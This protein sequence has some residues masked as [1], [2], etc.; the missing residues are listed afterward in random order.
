MQW[1]MIIPYTR[2]LTWFF[3]LY[4][5]YSALD[6]GFDA[7]VA[8]QTFFIVS[9]LVPVSRCWLMC[10]GNCPI[11]TATSYGMAWQKRGPLFF[12]YISWFFPVFLGCSP[13]VCKVKS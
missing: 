4:K 1:V 10:R 3:L 12:C 5:W 11:V 2:E 9:I 7:F 8:I 13:P 6:D